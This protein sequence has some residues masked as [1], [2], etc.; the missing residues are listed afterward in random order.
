M[1]THDHDMTPLIN[2]NHDVLWLIILELINHQPSPGVLYCFLAANPLALD[3]FRNRRR[4]YTAVANRWLILQD[5]FNFYMKDLI[6]KIR[7]GLETLREA[8]A[9]DEAEV[10]L[11]GQIETL[12]EDLERL[13]D[14][15]AA[16]APA[17]TIA[18][19]AVATLVV[20][21]EI[22]EMEKVVEA[23]RTFGRKCAFA[24]GGLDF[25]G[26]LVGTKQQRKEF[27]RIRYK[28]GQKGRAM[29]FRKRFFG[30]GGSLE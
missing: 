15:S 29:L 7:E 24:E 25:L 23:W 16:V 5:H 17:T 30:I 9:M 12:P 14:H 28:E 20:D 26:R 18:L 3:L 4:G 1:D 11:D 27:D 13:S 21:G 2:R 19:S 8:L 10:N 22:E 6:I